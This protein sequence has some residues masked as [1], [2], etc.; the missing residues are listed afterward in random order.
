MTHLA[1][2]PEVGLCILVLSSSEGL[3]HTVRSG[4]MVDD[5]ACKTADLLS[6]C[7]IKYEMKKYDVSVEAFQS[8][9]FALCAL[10]R[11]A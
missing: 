10:A 6:T 9:L 3:I 8:P 1:W 5:T 7:S 11:R 4:V 2:R